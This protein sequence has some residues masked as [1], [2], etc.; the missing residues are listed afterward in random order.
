MGA[1]LWWRFNEKNIGCKKDDTHKRRKQKFTRR[2]QG[3][4]RLCC[5]IIPRH[6]RS[7]YGDNLLDVEPLEAITMEL[8]DEE[9][10]AVAEWF[11]DHKVRFFSSFT[12]TLILLLAKIQLSIPF[13]YGWREESNPR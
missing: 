2:N 5:L 13:N 1:V 10:A 6:Y 12:S 8:D 9:D 11:Y 4:F 7:D 3:H